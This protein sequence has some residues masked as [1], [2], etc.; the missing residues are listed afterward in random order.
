MTGRAKKPPGAWTSSGRRPRATDDLVRTSRVAL[1]DGL[2]ATQGSA[3]IPRSRCRGDALDACPPRRRRT[4]VHP[5]GG[6][7]PPR[8]SAQLP[9]P[10]YP[11]HS[12]SSRRRRLMRRLPG[13]V[14]SSR[15]VRRQVAFAAAHHVDPALLGSTGGWPA[16]AQLTASAG[17]DLVLHYV[18]EEVLARLGPER[19][20][21]LAQLA[22]V[23]GGDD[24]LASALAGRE[25][26]VDDVIASPTA[27]S[28]TR[29][30]RSTGRGSPGGHARRR[31]TPAG[32]SPGARSGPCAPSSVK[33]F[34]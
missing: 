11:I 6:H 32:G 23:G 30:A 21:L 26:S 34:R 5:P 15:D 29:P 9:C 31:G 28:P 1:R 13:C 10:K 18:R 22:E 27:S 25:V 17:A 19:A 16:L 14:W 7:I 8:I 24:E 20:R 2:A 33:R 12:G 4:T 3:V